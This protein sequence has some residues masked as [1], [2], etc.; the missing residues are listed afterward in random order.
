MMH[1]EH[2]GF[3]TKKYIFARSVIATTVLSRYTEISGGSITTKIDERNLTKVTTEIIK[4]SEIEKFDFYQKY[5]FSQ[6]DD[7]MTFGK[8]LKEK[9]HAYIIKTL[10]DYLTQDQDLLIWLTKKITDFIKPHDPTSGSLESSLELGNLVNSC[11]LVFYRLMAIEAAIIRGDMDKPLRR[12]PANTATISQLLQNSLDEKKTA[13]SPLQIPSRLEVPEQE[14]LSRSPSQSMLESLSLPN[15]PS[16]KPSSLLEEL[17]S[18]SSLEIPPEVKS[19]ET[20][21]PL[22]APEQPNLQAVSQQQDRVLD[23]GGTLNYD[24]FRA[25]SVQASEEVKKKPQLKVDQSIW[26]YGSYGWD[27]VTR[28]TRKATNIV[29]Q[30]AA[31]R[32][33]KPF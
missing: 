17:T 12:A 3:S 5:I 32:L 6:L 19:P 29:S 15:T 31:G 24:Y 13:T 23:G 10:D 1:L 18:S 21:S 2:M 9:D 20:Q 11:R 8:A 22:L 26:S 4:L 33:P 7:W 28:G 27:L 16:P 30:Q 14:P 25:S